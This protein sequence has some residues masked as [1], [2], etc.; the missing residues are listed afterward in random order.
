MT[1]GRRVDSCKSLLLCEWG[2]SVADPAPANMLVVTHRHIPRQH[3]IDGGITRQRPAN[4]THPLRYRC[5][6]NWLLPINLT[7][8]VVIAGLQIWHTW[9]SGLGDH[10]HAGLVGDGGGGEPCV[11]MIWP[12]WVKLVWLYNQRFSVVIWYTGGGVNRSNS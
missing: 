3:S 9:K 11:F 5:D 8:I 12:W 7:N 6:N 4:T 10:N 2:S 1:S